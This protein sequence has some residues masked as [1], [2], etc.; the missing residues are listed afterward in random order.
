LA[1]VVGLVGNLAPI[2]DAQAQAPPQWY[3]DQTALPFTALANATAYYGIYQGAG[4]RI[5][6]PINWNGEL[7]MYAH[8]FR[9]D[10][11]ALTVDNPPIREHL[12]AQ[13]YAWAASSFATNGYNPGGGAEDTHALLEFFNHS[14]GRPTR[15]YMFGTSMGGHITGAMIERWPKAFAGAFPTCGNMGDNELF[16][17]WLDTYVAGETLVGQTPQVPEPADWQTNGLPTLLTGLGPSY[18]TQLN[19]AGLK[20]KGIIKNLSG[21][22]RPIFEQ[23]WSGPLSFTGA[24]PL[25]ALAG[26]IPGAENLHTVYRWEDERELTPEERQFNQEV[27]RI[28]ADPRYRTPWG[29]TLGESFSPTLT[30]DIEVPV[31]S[32]HTLG[33][34]F[35]PFKMEQVYA[36]RVARHGKSRLL[37]SRAIRDVNH[38]GFTLDELTRGFD[39][40]TTW[41]E[42]GVRPEGDDILDPKVVA[43]P[44]FGCRFTEGTSPTRTGLP[45][46]K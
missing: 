18:P 36:R 11:P 28:A 29:L 44:N 12:I 22:E 38:C 41:V 9:G 27:V 31:V 13:G 30:G 34:L 7:V 37:V 19:A 21:G 15:V 5:E 25:L 2:Q 26:A 8:G 14:F 39:D 45:A 40:L 17:F 42:H 35:V 32:L 20:F 16:D 23:G 6:I 24:I 10:G 3:V 33:E 4:Y 1:L 43:A 46:C